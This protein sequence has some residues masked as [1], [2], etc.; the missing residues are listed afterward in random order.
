MEESWRNSINTLTVVDKLIKSLTLI[1]ER[2]Q[3]SNIFKA[4]TFKVKLLNLEKL[5]MQIIFSCYSKVKKSII[6][7]VYL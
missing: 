6:Q 1:F 4:R 7:E 2:I 5:S 3:Q